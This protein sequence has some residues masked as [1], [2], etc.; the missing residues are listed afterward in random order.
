MLV[1]VLVRVTSNAGGPQYCSKGKVLSS[2]PNCVVCGVF[3]AS[4]PYEA[5]FGE[6]KH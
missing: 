4:I 5:S 1:N 6:V 3:I 2:R